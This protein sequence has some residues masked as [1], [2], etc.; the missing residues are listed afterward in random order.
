MRIQLTNYGIISIFIF[1]LLLSPIFGQNAE[2]PFH[3]EQYKLESGF[4]NGSG[5]AESNSENVF[6]SIVKSEGAPWIA[7]RFSDA[8]LGEDSYI[9]VKSLLDNH[10]Q[11]LNA[12]SIK[13]WYYSSAYFNGEAVEISLFVAPNDKEVFINVEEVIVGEWVDNNGIESIC[14]GND[15]R[16][17]SNHPAV[18]RI[19]SVGCT[20]WIIP[21]GKIVSA[22]HCYAGS[23]NVLQFNVPMSLPNGT[24]QH[25]GPQ[26]QYSVNSASRVFA[27]SGV[28]NDWGVAEVFP[29]SVTTLMPIQAQN[30]FFTL[31]QNLGPDTIRITGYGVDGPP[32]GFGSGVRDST[33]QTQQTHKGPNA[34]STGVTMRY[35]ADTQGGNSGS[36]IIDEATGS[37]VGVHTHGGCTSTGGS[38]AGTSFFRPEFWTAVSQGIPVELVSFTA[39]TISKDVLLSWSTASETNNYG[40]EIE[41]GINGEYLK[42]GFVPGYGT[43]T[44]SRNYSYTD[45]N[46]NSGTYNYRLKQIDLDGTFEY[47]SEIEVDITVPGMFSLEQNYPNPFNPSTKITFSLASESKITLKIYNVLGQEIA[48]L[49]N[50]NL[51]AQVHNID[52]DASEFN[53]GVYFYSLEARG[54]DGTNFVQTRK[55]ILMK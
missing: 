2:I 33:N 1:T 14:D 7:V 55:M 3:I 20:G 18:G 46:I 49:I 50:R 53:S 36:P 52:F 29:N 25:P 4:Y 27:N 10:W 42:V 34:N 9:I 15:F 13:E 22:G 31:V 37:S 11:R 17:A 40:F 35:R 39:T 51:P 12:K 8:N 47:S 24:I 32:P 54:V 26:D 44:E 5:I 28:G 21:N 16:V 19:I 41:R 23:A 30:A 45:Q 48:T 38:N 43:T 6:T